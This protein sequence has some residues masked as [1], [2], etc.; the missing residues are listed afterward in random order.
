MALIV[1]KEK[2]ISCGTCVASHGEFFKMSDDGKSEFTGGDISAE[3]AQDAIAGC[4][5]GAISEA[6]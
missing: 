5:V 2:C 6:E 4:P 3:D 1:D